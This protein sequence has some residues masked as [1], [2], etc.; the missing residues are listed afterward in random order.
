MGANFNATARMEKFQTVKGKT[1]AI[2]A[3]VAFYIIC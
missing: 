2:L 3:V 1:S